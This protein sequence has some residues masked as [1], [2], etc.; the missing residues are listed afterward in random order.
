MKL[1]HDHGHQQ[2][3]MGYSET[4]VKL[5]QYRK[6]F[7]SED[8]DDTMAA[9]LSALLLYF[10][11]ED[12]EEMI[13]MY[14]HCNGGAASGLANIYDVMQMISA[15]IKTV[16]IGKCYSAA[17]VLLAAGSKGHRYAMKNASIMIHGIQAGF[18]IPGHDIVS[19]KNYFDFLKNNNDDIMKILANHTGHP[20]EKLKEDC[21][22][23]V[24]MN[25]KQAL[26]YGLIDKII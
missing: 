4:Y 21:K 11:N 16:C 6:I 25:A 18:P 3:L 8:V 9:Q 26:A 10:D 15:P 5:A 2:P 12:P 23:D 1:G 20:L 19:S 17:A 13:E 24:W 14:I 22:Q 7:I